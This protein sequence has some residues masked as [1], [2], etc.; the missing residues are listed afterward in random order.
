MKTPTIVE[1]VLNRVEDA[2][3]LDGPAD[4]LAGL[5]RRV[6]RPGVA[7]D[8]L[9]GT[10]VGHPLHPALVAVPIGAWTTALA[11]DLTGGDEVAARRATAL[12]TLS[13]LPAALTGANDWLTTAGPERR[14]GLVH[15]AANYA[16]L[17]LQV[18]S[19]VARRRGR[20][21][22]GAALSA[23]AMTFVGAAGWLGGHLSYAMGVGVDTTAFQKLP[24][25]WLDVAAEQDVPPV[26]AT[27]VDAHGASVLL[28]RC[29]GSI[30]ALADRCTHRGGPLHEGTLADGC[31][32]CPWHGSV[33][34]LS[35]GTVVSGPASRPQPQLEVDVSDGRVR[36]RREE[37]RTLRTNPVGR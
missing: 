37:Q 36:V 18:G 1:Q 17:F 19:W 35:D 28:T 34:R 31:V 13:A 29:E 14:V 5:L 24:S 2:D 27:R 9:S 25:D 33:F 20:R 16:G 30:V 21:V 22:T 3:A 10:P 23:G 26:G 15:A 6:I 8:V 4:L 7:E 12:G 11:L 32:T